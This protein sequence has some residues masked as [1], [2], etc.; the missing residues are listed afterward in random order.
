MNS[1]I[2]DSVFNIVPEASARLAEEIIRRNLK[3]KWT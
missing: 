3:I 1:L 2:V